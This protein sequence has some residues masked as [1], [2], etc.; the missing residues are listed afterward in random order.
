MRRNGAVLMFWMDCKQRVTN[1][2][3]AHFHFSSETNPLRFTLSCFGSYLKHV[4][5]HTIISCL[6]DSRSLGHMFPSLIGFATVCH[7]MWLFKA[8]TA[9]KRTAEGQRC[10][11]PSRAYRAATACVFFAQRERFW[12]D[13]ATVRLKKK[14]NINKKGHSTLCFSEKCELQVSK[15]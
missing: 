14:S 4:S 11:I 9:D 3:N 15:R 1:L 10:K 8:S 12:W 2:I 5:C 13:L 6:F 7:Q